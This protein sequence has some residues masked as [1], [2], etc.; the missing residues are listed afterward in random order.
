MK[1]RIARE[2]PDG[3]DPVFE[4]Y[5]TLKRIFDAAEYVECWDEI[6]GV[7]HPVGACLVLP[8]S[9]QKVDFNDLNPLNGLEAWLAEQVTQGIE[10]DEYA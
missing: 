1:I 9:G 7:E 5:K 3:L 2:H 4:A 6:D 8:G 10:V